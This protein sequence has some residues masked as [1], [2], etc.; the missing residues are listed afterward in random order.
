M[1]RCHSQLRS[2]L[3]GPRVCISSL[4]CEDRLQDAIQVSS[5]SPVPL[6]PLVPGDVVMTTL[7][8][9]C[10]LLPPSRLLCGVV[11]S[12]YNQWQRTPCTCLTQ[13]QP[14]SA[15]SHHNSEQ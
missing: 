6:L 2:K 5:T 8:G 11:C 4:F 12:V 3:S 15:C 14:G 1:S 13:P 10:Y 7:P 9:P